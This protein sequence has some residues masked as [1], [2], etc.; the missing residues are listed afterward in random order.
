MWMEIILAYATILKPAR[1]V[2]LPEEGWLMAEAM[3]ED[4]APDM[5]RHVEPAGGM[6]MVE[7][8]A[9]VTDGEE[10]LGEARLQDSAEAREEAPGASIL[11]R[12]KMAY[13]TIL[14]NQPNKLKIDYSD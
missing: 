2:C 10:D 4:F 6:H 1:T 14:K 9:R 5:A 3:E 11:I 7:V 8:T 13:A 12:T